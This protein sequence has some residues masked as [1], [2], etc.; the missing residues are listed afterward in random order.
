MPNHLKTEKKITIISALTEGC[1]IRAIERMTGIHRDTIMRLGLRVGT[2]CHKLMDERMRDLRCNHIQ[3]DEIWGFVKMKQANVKEN[4]KYFARTGD[5]YTFV[6]LDTDTKL[7]PAYRIGKRTRYHATEFMRDLASRMHNKIQLSSDSFSAYCNA[8]ERGFGCEID[9]G[10]IVKTFR[11]SELETRRYS[12]PAIFTASRSAICGQPE[13]KIT[14]SHVEAQ[15]LTMRMHCRRLTR[16]T[17]AFSKK[18]VNFKAAIALHFAYYNFVKRHNTL[19]MTPAMAAGV[20]QSQW[21]IAD[22]VKLDSLG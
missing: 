17:N 21:E 5:A 22:L 13:R 11:A 20:S 12:P 8:V 3:V 19:R 15:N 14:T 1:S 9:Y 18:L 7:V 2:A 16:L 6:A 10:Q 4:Q